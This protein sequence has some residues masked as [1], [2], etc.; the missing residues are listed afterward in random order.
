MQHC[1]WVK[2]A[3]SQLYS[4]D[5]PTDIYIQSSLAVGP[6]IQAPCGY[7]KKSTSEVYLRTAN[8]FV[9]G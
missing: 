8:F 6:N 4:N 1:K 3:G 5:N 7:W 9:D 2:M